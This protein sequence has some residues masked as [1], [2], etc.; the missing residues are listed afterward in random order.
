MNKIDIIHSL[1][2][3]YARSMTEYYVLDDAFEKELSRSIRSHCDHA[4]LFDIARQKE[5]VQ[6]KINILSKLIKEVM[7]EAVSSSV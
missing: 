3:D 6:N 7:N 5:T 4:Y 1:S 2:N